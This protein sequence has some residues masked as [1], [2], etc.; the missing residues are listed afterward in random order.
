GSLGDAAGSCA[1]VVPAPAGRPCA[2]DGDPCTADTCDG[3][4]TCMHTPLSPEACRQAGVD[5]SGDYV[6]SLLVPFTVRALQTGS[7][8][9]LTGHVIYRSA[10]YPLSATGT[11]DPP[12]GKFSVT[13]PL[14][15]PSPHV[16]STH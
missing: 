13:P 8:L 9:Q 4:G 16:P 1:A 6:G 2:G 3:T 5:L 10:T 11:V 12:T 7:A 15:R 14:P